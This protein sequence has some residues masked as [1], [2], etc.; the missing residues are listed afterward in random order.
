MQE[1]FKQVKPHIIKALQ[2]L[3][4]ALDVVI[5]LQAKHRRALPFAIDELSSRLTI[6]RGLIKQA[7]WSAP[8]LTAA[9][10]WYFLPW[11]ILR[12]SRLLATLNIPE[13]LPLPTRAQGTPKPRLFVDMG[14][15]PLSLPI[16]LWLA[17]PEWREHELNVL[18][19]DTSPHPLQLGQKLFSIIAGERSPWRIIPVRSQLETAHLEMHKIDAVP[20]LISAANVCNEL[21]L[22]DERTYKIMEHLRPALKASDSSLLIV[23]PGTRL[24]GKTIVALRD[25]ALEYDLKPISPCPH[26]HECPLEESRTWCHFTFDTHASPKWLNDLS[27]AAKLRKEA[28]SL[29]FILLAGSEKQ[30]QSNKARIIS[31]PFNVPN[32]M[33]ESRYACCEQGLALLSNAG[34]L[35]S[36]ALVDIKQSS[37]QTRTDSKSGALI[38]EHAE[39][40]CPAPRF[41]RQGSKPERTSTKPERSTSRSKSE[42]QAPAEVKKKPKKPIK[43]KKTTKKFWEQ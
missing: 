26:M 38:L 21:K 1:I 33:G 27:N 28:L 36:G 7:Y 2:D 20:W 10:M 40:V 34:A 35:P 19:L 17:K 5:P 13:P 37:N 24:G 43:S 23:E 42:R 29:A 41:E 18:C 30:P 9:Y 11:N 22:Q 15:G 12:L 6:E 3:P 16:A 8:R 32:L 39:K 14:S 25:A 31:A 4:K